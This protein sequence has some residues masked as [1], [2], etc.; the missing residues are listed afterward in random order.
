MIIQGMGKF[1]KFELMKFVQVN[2]MQ[3]EDPLYLLYNPWDKK[4][5]HKLGYLSYTLVID[6]SI[7]AR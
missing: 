2:F 7:H 1:C 5:F 4:H 3:A 6:S